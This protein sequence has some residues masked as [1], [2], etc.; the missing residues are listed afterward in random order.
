MT[1]F[2]SFLL[3]LA[4]GALI[5]AAG[6]QTTDSVVDNQPNESISPL[7][8]T[9]DTSKV[10]SSNLTGFA[11]Y[12]PANDSLIY[13]HNEDRYFTPASNTKLFTF[14][15]GLKLLPDSIRALEYTV[16]G[17]SLIFWGTGDPSFLHS[18]MGNGKVYKFLKNREEKL[19][20]SDANFASKRFGPGW[21][22]DDS[23]YYYQTEKSPLPMYGN[24]VSFKIEEIKQRQIVTTDSGLAVFPPI[25]R[26]YI[27]EVK[28]EHDA[29][30]LF[31]DFSNNNFAYKPEADTNRYTI[32][33]PYHYT[34][35]LITD[36]LADTLGKT[37]TY[38]P[39]MEKPDSTSIIYSIKADTAYKR[40]LQP[41]DNFIAEQLLLV[42]AAELGIPLE[43]RAVI[44]K[45]KEEYLNVLPHEPQWVDGSG[46]S[47]YNMFTPRSMIR[48]LW[49][50]DDEF[51][52]NEQLFHLL[53]AG[54]ERGTIKDSYI[55]PQQD[56]PYVFAKTGTLSNNHCLSGYLI[57]ESGKKFIFSFMNNHYVTSTSVVEE[58]MNKV[59]RYI[60]NH[61]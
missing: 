57:T 41:S 40:M 20:Y 34:P 43:S 50:I 47:R 39:N 28:R 1:K 24:T 45:M 6:C 53:P 22:W 7:S 59:L 4:V 2:R 60:Y 44:K 15:A 29:P 35:Q 32:D 33:K 36:M 10:F 61:F 25:F 42:A 12:D 55:P 21:A 38:L 56:S 27:N 23:N 51:T 26:S 14:Y 48:L 16:R 8:V 54:G 19:Y 52:K 5:L 17:D 58:E 37:V 49:K 9:F 18:K 11:L 13:G 3:L 46:L 31:R 30:I